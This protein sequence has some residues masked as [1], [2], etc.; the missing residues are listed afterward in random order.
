MT[1]EQLKARGYELIMFINQ[2]QTELAQVNQ[3]INKEMEKPVEK[4]VEE[5]VNEDA[6]PMEEVKK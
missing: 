2:A 4:P 3:A 1:L 5:P 6:K